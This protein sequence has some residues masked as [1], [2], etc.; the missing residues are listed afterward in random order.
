MTNAT[1]E[2]LN[3]FCSNSFLIRRFNQT[4]FTS[5]Y[6]YHSEYELT[7]IVK[8]SGNRYIGNHMTSYSTGDLALLGANLPHCWK[9]DNVVKNQINA[10][11]IVI[12]FNREFLGSDFFSKPELATILQLLERSAQGIHFLNNT[13]KDIKE[14]MVLIAEE[15][16]SFKSLILLLEILYILATSKEYTLLYQQ[17][18]IGQSAVKR[19]RINAVLQYI[20]ENFKNDILLDEAAAISHMTP[21]AFCK[22]YKKITGRT[23]MDTVIDYRINHAIHQVINTEKSIS[24]ICFDSGFGDISHFHKLFKSKTSLSP[25]NYRKKFIS[26]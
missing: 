10:S 4:E 16:N 22:Y 7:L 17:N 6:H 5:P 9:S 26:S 25:L 19:E 21:N 14:R 12:Q 20:M 13:V 3:P 1:F 15:Q 8:G 2:N 23:F 24:D 11:S 18:V